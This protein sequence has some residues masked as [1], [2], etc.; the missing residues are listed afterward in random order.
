V[1]SEYLET[2]SPEEVDRIRALMAAQ[3]IGMRGRTLEEGDWTSVYCDAKGIPQRGWS[4]LDIDVVANSGLGVEHKQLGTGVKSPTTKCG[5]RAMHPAMTRQIDIPDSA[6]PNEVMAAVLGQ[7]AELVERRR[8][9][10]NEL[11][12]Q[13]ADLRLGWL[14]WK[15]DLSEF[16]YFEERMSAPKPDDYY[17]EWREHRSRRRQS[18]RN[19]W[20]FERE[21]KIKRYSITTSR[22]PKIQPYFD[23]P[24]RDDPALYVIQA[25]GEEAEPDVVRL[26]VR[27]STMRR[28]NQFIKAEDQAALSEFILDSVGA[29][30]IDESEGTAPH[31][32]A[33]PLQVSRE[34]YEAVTSALSG[35]TTDDRLQRLL[36]TLDA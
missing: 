15:T 22:G 11:T 19:V 12:G 20:V 26:W 23:V 14:L 1:A 35:P 24:G 10:V 3:V 25:E 18:S 5:G 36:D 16:M 21:T 28:L 33:V 31:V 29:V 4:N 2:F 9:W 34:A 13:E 17:A 32:P 27:I 6:D 7:Y 30:E 8:E